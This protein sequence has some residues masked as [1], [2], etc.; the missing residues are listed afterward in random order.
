MANLKVLPFLMS[1]D[2]FTL[3]YEY[4][5]QNIDKALPILQQTIN[6]PGMY[7]YKNTAWVITTSL[8]IIGIDTCFFNRE[9]D[10][11][12]HKPLTL[13]EVRAFETIFRFLNKEQRDF[14]YKDKYWKE[15][16]RISRQTLKLKDLIK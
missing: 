8:N 14:F 9:F 1:D 3:F 13:K 6:R 11:Y 12:G 7:R 4:N 16:R 10:D 2:V 15:C 5:L